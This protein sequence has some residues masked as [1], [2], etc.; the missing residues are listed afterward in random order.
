MKDYPLEEL[1]Q[2]ALNGS[3]TT[4]NKLAEYYRGK[5]NEDKEFEYVLNSALLDD[6]QAMKILSIMLEESI[7]CDKNKCE[8]QI[9]INKYNRRK[10]EMRESNIERRVCEYASIKGWLCR[11]YTSPGNRGVPDRIFFKDG[12][13]IMVEFKSKEGKLSAAQK[14]GI[15]I[16]RE[17]G[18]QV[19]VI[20]SIEAGITLFDRLWKT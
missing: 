16:H 10:I 12:Q 13:T 5:G 6:V 1:E 15:K 17:H 3:V 14:V 7:G 4:S 20:S 8:S 19:E 9:W 18:M 2:E 11:K